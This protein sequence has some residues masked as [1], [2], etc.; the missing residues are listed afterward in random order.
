MPNIYYFMFSKQ[1][2]NMLSESAKKTGRTYIPGTVLVVGSIKQFTEI[3]K[4]PNSR[5]SDAIIVTKGELEK[6]KYTEPK[7]E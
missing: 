6:I 2:M 3:L 1:Q 4:E 7:I 5:F